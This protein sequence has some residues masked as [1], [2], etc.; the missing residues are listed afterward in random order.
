MENALMEENYRQINAQQEAYARELHDFKHHLMVIREYVQT[1]KEPELN[2]YI[3]SLLKTSYAGMLQCHSGN[4]IIDAV[5]NCKSAEAKALDIQF[6][7]ITGLYTPIQIDPINICGVLANQLD[8]AFDACKL[9]S[10]PKDRNVRVEIKQIEDMVFFI[11]K[12]T[13]E[14]NPFETDPQLHS[15]KK[16]DGKRHGYG[17]TNICAIAEKYNGCMQTEYSSGS[18]ISSV[19]LCCKP[20]DT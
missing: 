10:D 4:D 17:L 9:I 7:F 11:V 19:S 14:N 3:D 2:T 20:L 6:S 13:V 16:S 5:I 8:N 12:N 1:H 15:T 18:F